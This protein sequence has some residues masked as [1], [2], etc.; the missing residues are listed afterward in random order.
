MRRSP[1]ARVSAH[2]HR[3]AGHGRLWTAT[4]RC[5]ELPRLGLI[6]HPLGRGVDAQPR[7]SKQ[8]DQRNL[9]ERTDH[10]DGPQ[11]R[12]LRVSPLRIAIPSK[13]QVADLVFSSWLSRSSTRGYPAGKDQ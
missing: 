7:K 3:P 8:R 1:E 2:D 5:Q 4:I 13:G 10:P 9:G 6:L 12:R 11:P